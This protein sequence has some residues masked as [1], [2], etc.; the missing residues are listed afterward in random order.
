MAVPGNA[1]GS[2]NFGANCEFVLFECPQFNKIK[3]D[4]YFKTCKNYVLHY[5]CIYTTYLNHLNLAMLL[6]TICR[7]RFDNKKKFYE[8]HIIINIIIIILIKDWIKFKLFSLRLLNRGRTVI[9][10]LRYCFQIVTHKILFHVFMHHDTKISNILSFMPTNNFFLER[11]EALFES[12]TNFW[13]C[14]ISKKK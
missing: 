8:L 12:Y 2:L 7:R 4:N 10:L 3:I 9:V 5:L 13:V 6:L 14:F 1:T 11:H